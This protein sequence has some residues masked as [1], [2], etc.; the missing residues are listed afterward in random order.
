MIINKLERVRV[1]S[2]LG[3]LLNLSSFSLCVFLSLCVCVLK[4]FIIYC[5]FHENRTHTH[6]ISCSCR[7]AHKYGHVPP[8]AWETLI[9]PAALFMDGAQMLL[10]PRLEYE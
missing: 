4:I 3:S 10:S 1:F 5:V 6:S 2:V 9:Y 8:W 7:Y